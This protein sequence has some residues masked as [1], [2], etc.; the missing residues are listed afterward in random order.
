MQISDQAVLLVVAMVVSFSLAEE[1]RD[2]TLCQ[3]TISNRAGAKRWRPQ[4]LMDWALLLM[5]AGIG[6]GL[7]VQVSPT[8]KRSMSLSTGMPYQ[9]YAHRML[10]DA[11]DLICRFSYW[12]NG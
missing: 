6:T 12:V 2:I 3:I 7:Y 9:A 10:T 8:P 1:M 11:L 4:S 5:C